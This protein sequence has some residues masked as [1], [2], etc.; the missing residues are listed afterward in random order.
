METV[1]SGRLFMLSP[2]RDLSY[3]CGFVSDRYIVL[4]MAADALNLALAQ[5]EVQLFKMQVILHF[6]HGHG[7]FLIIKDKWTQKLWPSC[8]KSAFSIEIG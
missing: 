8:Q 4:T 2:L 7:N 6:E 5:S 1:D 3:Y